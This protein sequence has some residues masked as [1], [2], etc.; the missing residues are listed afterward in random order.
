M[1]LVCLAAKDNSPQTQLSL[2]SDAV[3]GQEKDY[4]LFVKTHVIDE[5]KRSYTMASSYH[6]SSI[7]ISSKEKKKIK[8]ALIY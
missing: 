4:L 2:L 3:P 7:T 5:R 8:S 1:Y 6:Y